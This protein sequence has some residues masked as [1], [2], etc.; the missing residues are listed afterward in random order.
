MELIKYIFA[1]HKLGKM[2][3]YV[4]L[5]IPPSITHFERR[6]Y[7]HK[8]NNKSC[9]RI[10]EIHI[11]IHKGF[12]ELWYQFF[13][14]TQPDSVTLHCSNIQLLFFGILNKIKMRFNTFNQMFN[15]C[16]LF[17][18]NQNF[19]TQLQQTFCNQF[20]FLNANLVPQ[21]HGVIS[22]FEYMTGAKNREA[23]KGERKQK[24]PYL[25][26]ARYGRT[27]LVTN[28]AGHVAGGALRERG[29]GEGQGDSR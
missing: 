6:Y 8:N 5:P 14:C 1:Q 17:P 12:L 23:Q 2:S 26:T 27:R 20:F 24:L 13:I 16:E 25:L 18:S 19:G 3:F 29:R 9:S 4:I 21:C 28:E 7:K 11:S 22:R 10:L 15:S